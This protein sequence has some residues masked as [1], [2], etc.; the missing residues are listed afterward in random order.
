MIAINLHMFLNYKTPFP[1]KK[2]TQT[3]PESTCGK[4]IN[5]EGEMH[6]KI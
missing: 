3:G 4:S 2:H 5:S 1:L 6:S